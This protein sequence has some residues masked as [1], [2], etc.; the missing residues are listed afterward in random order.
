MTLCELHRQLEKQRLELVRK[1]GV[2]VALGEILKCPVC[3]DQPLSSF[4]AQE[5][6]LFCPHCNMEIQLKYLRGDL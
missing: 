2:Q 1:I 5:E 4:G 6:I 3:I